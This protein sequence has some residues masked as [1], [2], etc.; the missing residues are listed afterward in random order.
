MGIVPWTQARRAAKQFTI[1]IAFL[2]NGLYSSAIAQTSADT[3]NL[4]V[5]HLRK[6]L[7]AEHAAIASHPNDGSNYIDLAYTLTDAGVGDQARLAAA[8][9]TRVA[10]GDAL[11]YSAQAWVLHHNSIGVDYGNGF[12]YDGALRA[13]KRA[14][15]LDPKDLGVRSSLANLLE[16]NRQGVRYAPDAQLALAIEAYR[17][18]KQHERPLRAD[19]VDNLAINLFYAGRYEEAHN[20][21]KNLPGTDQHLGIIL[22]S[23]AASKGSSAAIEVAQ[24]IEGDEQRRKNALNFAAEGLWNKRLYPQAADLLTASLPDA[25]A[26]PSI[27]AKIR[28]FRNLAP[29]SASTL[30]STDPRHPVYRLLESAL[31]GTLD[32]TSSQELI[33]RHSFASEAGWDRSS[34]EMD[35]LADVLLAVIKKTGLPR[36]VVM[37]IVLGT[38]SVTVSSQTGH[39][40][41]VRAQVLGL[42]PAQFFLVSEDGAWKIAA[43]GQTAGQ[44]GTQALYLLEK[45]QTEAVSQMLDWYHSLLDSSAEANDPLSGNLFL[46]LWDPKV[47]S[48]NNAAMFAAAALATDT[49]LLKTVVPLIA[50][51]RKEATATRSRV[52]LDQLLANVYLKLK[53]APNALSVTT[54][55]LNQFPDST[56]A[57]HLAGRSF[58]LRRDWSAWRALLTK[59]L[60]S[61]PNDQLLLLEDADEAVAEADY[62]RARA[63]Y[64]RLRNGT[65]AKAN[66]D[67][68]YAWLSLFEGKPDEEA[69]AAA[70]RATLNAS[71]Q[72]YTSL[73]TLA[74]VNAAL[75]NAVEAHQQLLDAMSSA[76]LVQPDPGIWYGFGRIYEQY[77]I[78]DAA[79]AAYKRA[80]QQ[81]QT[82]DADSLVPGSLSASIL[83]DLRLKELAR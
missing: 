52:E 65:H 68:M 72:D 41:V 33:S 83:A 18:V 39:A 16:F 12:D 37:D 5:A 36:S 2:S 3:S 1:L 45:G 66:D 11:M 25:A 19:T 74:C 55:L 22:A 4:S 70:Q 9:A 42:A 44:V 23:L 62:P 24:T 46:R 76:N 35:H 17:F 26:G 64:G 51:A 80:L 81:G 69:L 47:R 63:A 49:D 34:Q 30:P 71:G 61:Q 57:V 21:L 38:M 53:D 75:G 60:Q 14:I 7:A 8:N 15:E 56:T 20:E 29:Y 32:Q 13:Y 40:A 27:S 6:S 77:G 50:Q 58:E 79:I 28:I 31:A 54:R 10:P 67:T 43:A 48:T 59:R 73:L 82:Q 78:P